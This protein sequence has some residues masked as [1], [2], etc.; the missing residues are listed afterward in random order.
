ME[1]FLTENEISFNTSSLLINSDELKQMRKE[2]IA[3][4]DCSVQTFLKNV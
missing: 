2:T 3:K 4:M 1:R